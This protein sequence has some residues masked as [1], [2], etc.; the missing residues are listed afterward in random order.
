M[1]L[2]TDIRIVNADKEL[3]KELTRLAKENKRTVSRQAEFML[4]QL[5][6]T[7]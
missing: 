4:L 5:I 7:K 6:K 3:V 2:R 1:K